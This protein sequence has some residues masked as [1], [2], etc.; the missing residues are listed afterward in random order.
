MI[1]LSKTLKNYNSKLKAGSK[2]IRYDVRL[3]NYIKKNNKRLEF[4]GSY[5]SYICSISS[6]ITFVEYETLPAQNKVEILNILYKEQIKVLKIQS[7]PATPTKKAISNDY[8][9][10]NIYKVDN[11]SSL[12]QNIVYDIA[13]EPTKIPEIFKDYVYCFT[14]QYKYNSIATNIATIKKAIRT[15]SLDDD[16]KEL[17][18]KEFTLSGRVYDYLNAGSKTLRR[19]NVSLTGSLDDIEVPFLYDLVT[20]AND[21]V[22]YQVTKDNR[23]FVFTYLS[24]CISLA[25]GRRLT[26]I[27]YQSSF[28]KVADYKIKVIGLGKKRTDKSVEIIVPTLF[29]TADEVLR[30]VKVVRNIIPK[31]L[32][33]KE[34]I[35]KFSHNLSDFKLIDVFYGAVKYIGSKNAGVDTKIVFTYLKEYLLLFVGREVME[36]IA[37]NRAIPKSYSPE[38]LEVIKQIK[39]LFPEDMTNPKERKKFMINNYDVSIIKKVIQSNNAKYDNTRAMCVL[40]AEKIYNQNNPNE[41]EQKNQTSYLQAILGHEEGS[42]TYEHYYKRQVLL[43]GFDLLAYLSISKSAMI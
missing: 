31:S 3:K 2:K 22:N 39:S 17:A 1:D 13:E 33:T 20:K 30:A 35:E 19:N 32:K 18:L 29:L 36:L 12:A 27:V 41:R 6:A 14:Y 4:D 10:F 42:N 5:G 38:L 25:I 24:A 40:V 8:T 37:H 28:E 16:T 11:I 7:V 23:K 15:S 43:D 34:Q 21:V 26:E 9:N